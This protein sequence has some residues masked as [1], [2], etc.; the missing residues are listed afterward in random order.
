LFDIQMVTAATRPLGAKNISRED[1][2]RRL[3]KAVEQR[4]SF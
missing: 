2:L 4:C 1:Y 3:A